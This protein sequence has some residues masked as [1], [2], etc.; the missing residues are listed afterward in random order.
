[1]RLSGFTGVIFRRSYPEIMNPGA[2]WDESLEI[3]PAMGGTPVRSDA[4][5]IWPNGSWIKFSH[6]QHEQDV[7][8][9]QGSQ[10]AVVAFDEMTHF[11]QQMV[12][13][14]M[15]RLRTRCGMRPYL[16]GTCNPDPNSWVAEF[17]AG[18]LKPDGT[19]IDGAERITRYM[20]RDKGVI[21]FADNP[22]DLELLGMKPRS[23]SF[24][25]ALVY[26]N[27]SLLADNPDYEDNL[28]SMSAV[29]RSRLLEGNWKVRGVA[30]MFFKRD[31]WKFL[32][33]RPTDVIRWVR[34]WDRASTEQSEQ[35]PDP[36]WTVGALVGRRA[37]GG[38]V[39]GDIVRFRGTPL[40]V[41][42]TIKNT[43]EMDG[44]EVEVILEQDPGQ[45]GVAEV[46]YIIREMPEFNA[47]AKPVNRAKA[48]RA[49]PMSAQCEAGNLYLVRGKWNEAFI[50]EAEAFIDEREAKAP[51]GYH[52]DQI[53]AASGGYNH[54]ISMANPTIRSL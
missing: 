17:I 51:I 18:W 30:G 29:D 44:R 33:E 8:G 43:A 32:P 21:Q 6:M 35:S 37:S 46:A 36:D 4:K 54:L 38:F 28:K 11:S 42:N 2:L 52:D 15:S 27:P 16:R 20:A 50:T 31:W 23:V 48:E 39:I 10:L 13:Y 47:R 49:K 22:A 26:D 41:K 12:F 45:A 3:F 53:D 14:M 25:P 19:P 34:Y 9:W 1:M 40:T 24:I 7:H 5:W